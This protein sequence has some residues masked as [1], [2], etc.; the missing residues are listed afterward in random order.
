MSL[1]K[2]E[3]FFISPIQYEIYIQ[4]ADR[5]ILQMYP[6]IV[7]EESVTVYVYRSEED[8]GDD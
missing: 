6:E 2:D 1:L 5:A 3:R 7:R 8:D 4:P